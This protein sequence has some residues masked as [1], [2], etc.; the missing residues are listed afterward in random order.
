MPVYADTDEDHYH[1]LM[2]VRCWP[3]W[4]KTNG[5][6]FCHIFVTLEDEKEDKGGEKQ[7]GV[8]GM[9]ED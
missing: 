7:Q 4:Q 9:A 6:T 1:M 3:E 2:V 5:N 8:Q